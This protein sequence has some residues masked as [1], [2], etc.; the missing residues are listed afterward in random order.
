MS[1]SYEA[2]IGLEEVEEAG[3]RVMLSNHVSSTRLISALSPMAIS[4]MLT[5]QIHQ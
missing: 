2:F 5:P 4:P 1:I 3:T